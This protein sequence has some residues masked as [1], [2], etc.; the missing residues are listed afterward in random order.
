KRIGEGTFGS[1]YHALWHKTD[2][3]IKRLKHETSDDEEF[4]REAILMSSLRH[5][6]IVSCFGVSLTTNAKY[7][8]VEYMNNGSVEKAIYNSNQG[9]NVLRFNVKLKILISVAKGLTYLH[10]IKPHKIIHRDL[11]SAN[12]LLDSNMNAKVCDFGLSKVV[13]NSHTMTSNVGT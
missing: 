5:P 9:K 1:V 6:F 2:V 7:M 13:S 10:S 4:E 12:I 3:A 11:K 8:V